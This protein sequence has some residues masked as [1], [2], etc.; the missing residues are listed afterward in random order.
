MRQVAV[1]DAI[2]ARGTGTGISDA[3]VDGD[4][5]ALFLA[6]GDIWSLWMLLSFRAWCNE[7]FLFCVCHSS[8]SI[9]DSVELFGM[10][11]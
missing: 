3:D 7:R 2:E 5:L 6:A 9:G 8:M 1:Y 11:V 10:E 4:C